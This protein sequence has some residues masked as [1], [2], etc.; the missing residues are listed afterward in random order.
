MCGALRTGD[1][2]TG[3]STEE[4]RTAPG[5]WWPSESNQE[6][7][8]DLGRAVFRANSGGP[9]WSDEIV[10]PACLSR[11][12]F[13]KHA[14]AARLIHSVAGPDAKTLCV[15]RAAPDRYSKRMDKHEKHAHRGPVQ[16]GT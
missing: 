11:S 14:K 1:A 8:D 10:G 13:V 15:S 7:K 5:G 12:R 6:T 2:L 4:R 9:C 16:K 3:T